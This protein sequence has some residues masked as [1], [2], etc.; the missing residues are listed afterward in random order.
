LD[1]LRKRAPVRATTLLRKSSSCSDWGVF[2]PRDGY[3]FSETNWVEGSD[4]WDSWAAML[5]DNH[6]GIYGCYFDF[7]T[8]DYFV[9]TI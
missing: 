5:I 1:R 8:T 2:N 3:F 4:V 9:G 6:D 7:T